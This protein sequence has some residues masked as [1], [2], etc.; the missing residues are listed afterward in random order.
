MT[1]ILY[2]SVAL[3]AV[4]FVILAVFAAQTLRSLQ[5]TLNSV[6]ATLAEFEKQLR[7]VT[8]E[9]NEL[10]HRTNRFAEDL[11][12]KSIALNALFDHV[13]EVGQSLETINRSFRNVSNRIELAS[14]RH[15]EQV[16]K[17]FE[18][19]DAAMKIWQKWRTKKKETDDKH[20][21]S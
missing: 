7:G 17:V 21:K 13:K 15:S 5:N 16:G 19:S 6:A 1:W 14:E 11:Q 9:T 2:A 3:I 4:A 18:W 10:L 20:S 8:A 12:E